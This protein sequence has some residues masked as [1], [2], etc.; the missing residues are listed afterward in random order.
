MLQKRHHCFITK[1]TVSIIGNRKLIDQ[2]IG[3][4]HLFFKC[5]L[6]VGE[7]PIWGDSF[8]PTMV[9]FSQQCC[10]VWVPAL[11][12]RNTAKK[13][14]VQSIAGVSYVMLKFI[15][16]PFVHLLAFRFHATSNISFKKNQGF[17]IF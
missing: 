4:C 10:L 13:F 14:P 7:V 12:T 9:Q 8:W 17:N 15:N 16:V 6:F 1:K 5:S 3:N 11:P 2:L